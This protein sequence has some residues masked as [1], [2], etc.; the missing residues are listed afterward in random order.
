MIYLGADHAGFKLKEEIKQSLDKLGY[1]YQDLGN[2]ELEEKD[3]Y[4]DFGFKVAK[5]VVKQRG[6]KGLL[7]CGSGQGMVIVANKVKGVRAA[8]GFNQESAERSRKEDDANVLSIG[9]RMTSSKEAKKIVEVWL[10]TKFSKTPRH[11][12]RIKKIS[13]IEK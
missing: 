11:Q 10:K 9:A 13:F 1:K 7:F 2:W 12:R 6:A 5:K 3:D 4:P 8:L